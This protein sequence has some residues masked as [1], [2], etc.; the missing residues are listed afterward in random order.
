MSLAR[1]FARTYVGKT[2]ADLPDQALDYASMLIASTLASAAFGTGIES[3]KIT[4]SLALQPG[5][6]EESSLWY[7]GRK[8]P[9][10][11]AARV[12]AV[13]SDSAA[14]DDSDLRNIVHPGT[15]L[16]ATTLAL[17]EK[18]GS[19]GEEVLK[20]IVLGYD[21][22][23]RMG[24]AMTGM[25]AAGYHGCSIAI[26]GATVAAGVLVGLDEEQMTHAIALAATS[27]GG[28]MAAANTSIS[29]EYHAG[30][31]TLLAIEAARAAE[32]GYTGEEQILEMPRGFI[33]LHGGGDAALALEGLGD[34]WLILR[35]IAIKMVPG[36]HQYHASAEAAAA[37]ARA[38]NVAPEDIEQ[39]VVSRPGITSL[40]GP[41]HPK[42]LIDMAHSA[43]YFV[44]AAAADRDFGW[45][46]ASEAKILDP[47]INALCDRV[48]IGAQP[49]TDLER[50]KQGATVTIRTKAGQEHSATVFAPRGSGDNVRWD[51]VASKCHALMPA[52][53]LSDERIDDL[54]AAVK[55]LCQA[56]D[57]LGALQGVS[58]R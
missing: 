21:A 7:D 57:V 38:G 51:D 19:S 1:D 14:S 32:A 3:L 31:A 8:L 48:V 29:R 25:Y 16:T 42:D 26:F 39:I 12:N 36:A 40:A 46:H 52:A 2:A 30:L 17:G 27:I 58:A 35:E 44:A 55:A 33:A 22:Q 49:A 28:M 18:L 37:A 41:V 6:A 45:V 5:G 15:P 56:P 43:T 9:L 20:A 53:G 11:A 50:Y 54:L 10:A 34:E 13:M 24:S 4:K 23:A 47:V